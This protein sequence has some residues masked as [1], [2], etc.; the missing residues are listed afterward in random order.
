MLA[1]LRLF[2][3]TNSLGIAATFVI[4]VH[5]IFSWIAYQLILDKR[6][7]FITM[8]IYFGLLI[9]N[10]YRLFFVLPNL[11]VDGMLVSIHLLTIVFFVL[12][13]NRIRIWSTPR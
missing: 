5:T 8:T 1:D 12:M 11:K 7:A 3:Y 13:I 10:Y 6:W 4:A 9:V 2:I